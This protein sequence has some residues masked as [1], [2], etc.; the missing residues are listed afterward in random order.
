MGIVFRSSMTMPYFPSTPL[1]RSCNPWSRILIWSSVPC[2]L[3]L[4]LLIDVAGSPDAAGSD[5]AAAFGS[6]GE[7]WLQPVIE[8]MVVSAAMA[9][10]LYIS[11][12]I[13][14]TFKCIEKHGRCFWCSRR[15]DSSFLWQRAKRPYPNYYLILYSTSNA[16]QQRLNGKFIFCSDERV[17]ST[18]I[19]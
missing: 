2:T 9:I 6:S 18:N 8:M 7:P 15:S 17:C 1:A 16:E 4:M 11:D 14:N 10:S 3:S 12:F 5:S 13:V 19:L